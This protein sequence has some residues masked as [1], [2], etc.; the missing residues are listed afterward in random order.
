MLDS[1]GGLS[2]RGSRGDPPS[3]WWSLCFSQGAACPG[4]NKPLS[5]GSSASPASARWALALMPLLQ[6]LSS[7]ED[8]HVASACFPVTGSCV[9]LCVGMCGC[10][11]PLVTTLLALELCGPWFFLGCVPVYSVCESKAGD[12]Y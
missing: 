10:K 8:L 7:A 4:A 12:T 2:V 3:L 6:K 1:A 9:C 11:A 5:S